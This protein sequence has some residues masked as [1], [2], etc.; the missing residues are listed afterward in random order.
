MF[1]AADMTL[2]FAGMVGVAGVTGVP[3]ALRF[4]ESFDMGLM[5]WAARVSVVA[6][7]LKV[8][9]Y[10]GLLEEPVMDVILAG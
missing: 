10:T 4:F 2:V 8:T 5:S 3:S 7:D 6:Y 1:A 9:M